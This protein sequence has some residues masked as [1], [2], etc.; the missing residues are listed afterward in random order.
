MTKRLLN[1]LFLIFMVSVPCMAHRSVQVLKDG[2]IV[3]VGSKAYRTSIPTTAMGVLMN[4]K[5]YGP[6]ILEGLNY[7]KIDSTQFD[8]P[9]LFRNH[10]RLQ[11]LRPGQHA[12]LQIDGLSYSGIF[13]STKS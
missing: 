12:F 6:S 13:L 2:W 3:Q 1:V 4:N 9:W 11:P 7:H 5:V 10:F 8:R